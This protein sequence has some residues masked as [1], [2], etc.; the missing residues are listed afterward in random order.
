MRSLRTQQSIIS[1]QHYAWQEL[2]DLRFRVHGLECRIS[3]ILGSQPYNCIA[4]S[5]MAIGAS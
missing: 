4:A 5:C 2:P 1:K 3:S